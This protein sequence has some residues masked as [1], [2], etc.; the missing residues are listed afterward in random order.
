MLG[1]LDGLLDGL[2]QTEQAPPETAIDEA[3]LLMAM[4][5]AH[6]F[7]GFYPV[8]VIGRHEDSFYDRLQE[9]V[10]LTQGSAPFTI[11]ERKSSH[12]RYV[13]YHLELFVDTARLAL[14]RKAELAA[15][16]GV[17]WLL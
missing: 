11:R 1:D 7:P 4:E 9:A 16:D 3:Q 8:V 15:I 13:A 6:T 2:D 14:A 10:Q 17:L 5:E 12:G